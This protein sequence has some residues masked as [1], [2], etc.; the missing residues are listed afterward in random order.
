[1]KI[2]FIKTNIESAILTYTKTQIMSFSLTI[3][4]FQQFFFKLIIIDTTFSSKTFLALNEHI[5][6]W[7]TRT[8]IRKSNN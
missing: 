5:F 3:S 8:R 2:H 4:A 1:M 6:F 7:T